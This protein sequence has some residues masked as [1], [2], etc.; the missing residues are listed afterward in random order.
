MENLAL[1]NAEAGFQSPVQAVTPS[2]F[3][4]AATRS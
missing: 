3:A 2:S 4:T 1:A